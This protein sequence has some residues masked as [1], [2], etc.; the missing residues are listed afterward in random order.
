[1]INFIKSIGTWLLGRADKLEALDQE[2]RS[3]INAQTRRAFIYGAACG[4]LAMIA[5]FK[6]L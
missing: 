1:M 5:L 4:V 2:V 3:Q 6:M